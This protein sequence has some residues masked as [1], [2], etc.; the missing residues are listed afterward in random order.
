MAEIEREPLHAAQKQ[1]AIAEALTG[2]EIDVDRCVVCSQVRGLGLHHA[3]F[4]SK[5]GK[6]GP[7]V[8]LCLRCHENVHQHEWTLTLEADGLFL[9]DREG[10][11]VFRLL[12]WPLPGEAGQLVEMLDRVSEVEKL[13]PELAPALPT[14]QAV[15]V[16]NS[17]RSCYDSGWRA[18]TRLIGEFY[19]Y[20]MP[21]VAPADKVALLCDLFG[22]RRSQL[23]SYLQVHSAF[24]E[25]PALEG[26]RLSMGYAIEAARSQHPEKWLEVAEDRKNVHPSFSRDDLRQEIIRA[27]DRARP[28]EPSGEP[29]TPTVKHV[30]GRCSHCGAIDW[31]EKLPVGSDGKPV[32]VI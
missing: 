19:S 20:R 16:F 4:K 17:L 28:L 15:E 2:L 7:V 9:Y 22:L 14:W 8:P 25:S 18:Q 10:E 27:G 32:E 11:V 6:E 30:W 26:T 31:H 1:I 23:Y 3:V 24:R 21:G 5:G 29:E 12:R 13:M